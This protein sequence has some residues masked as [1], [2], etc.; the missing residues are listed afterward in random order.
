M[1]SI[2]K[3]FSR[4]LLSF[5]FRI[6]IPLGLLYSLNLL[7]RDLTSYIG[8]IIDLRKFIYDLIVVGAVIVALTFISRLFSYKS[9][10]GLAAL[11]LGSLTSLYYNLYLITLGNIQSLGFLRIPFPIYGLDIWA[12]I[13]YRTIIYLILISGFISIVKC[14]FDWMGSGP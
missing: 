13:E 11:I 1:G 5:I 6:G 12:S 7:P 8:N 10:V 3:A 4:A 9:K 14:F 2:L